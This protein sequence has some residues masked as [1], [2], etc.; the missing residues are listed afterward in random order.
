MFAVLLVC[1]LVSPHRGILLYQKKKKKKK[2]GNRHDS[3]AL[4]VSV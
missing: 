4:T 3:H 1:V 2:P